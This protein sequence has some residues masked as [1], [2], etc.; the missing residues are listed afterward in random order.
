MDATAGAIIGE[1]VKGFV[2]LS[3]SAQHADVPTKPVTATLVYQMAQQHCFCTEKGNLCG[4]QE[5]LKTHPSNYARTEKA[6]SLG[7]R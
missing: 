2:M 3:K 6:Q 5:R 7:T 1:V 4:T